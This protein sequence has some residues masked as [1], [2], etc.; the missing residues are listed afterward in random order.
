MLTQHTLS[1]HAHGAVKFTIIPTIK[2]NTESIPHIPKKIHIV[3]SMQIRH[4][5]TC[6][7]EELVERS[8]EI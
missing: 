4:N 1:I 8:V 5:S 3:I 2:E 7:N 6:C